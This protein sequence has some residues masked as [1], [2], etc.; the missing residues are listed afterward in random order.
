MWIS[1]PKQLVLQMFCYSREAERSVDATLFAH[2]WELREYYAAEKRAA[3][4][5]LTAKLRDTLSNA[6]LAS[7]RL[8]RNEIWPKPSPLG[9]LIR[10]LFGRWIAPWKKAW[11]FPSQEI[12]FIVS[13]LTTVLSFLEAG[14]RPA[15]QAL[16][17]LRMDLYTGEYLIE[18]R[19]HGLP[20][21]V[22]AQKIEHFHGPLHIRLVKMEDLI[23]Q[24]D[25]AQEQAGTF[26]EHH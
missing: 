7:P 16:I 12:R 4:A 17:D 24:P 20:E 9:Q 21:L 5:Q 1:V 2:W 26:Y 25:H 19:C 15:N 22:R 13:N 10:V 8:T 6:C 11:R 18:W 3:I 14:D 23:G